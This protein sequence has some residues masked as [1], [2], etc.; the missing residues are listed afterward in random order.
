MV[1]AFAFKIGD[2]FSII[3][4][5]AETFG[6]LLHAHP[7]FKTGSKADWICN[8]ASRFMLSWACNLNSSFIVCPLCE[9]FFQW[10]FFLLKDSYI[11]KHENI[12][13]NADNPQR[14]AL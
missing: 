10:L 9:T 7:D 2:N 4:L 5:L 6:Y 14:P 3:L 12:L 13:V 8:H 1:S 11:Y